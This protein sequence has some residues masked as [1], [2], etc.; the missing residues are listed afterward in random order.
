MALKNY[1]FTSESV[2]EGH[3]DKMCDQV[4]DAVL[5]AILAQDPMGR[6][7]CET[8]ITTGQVMI[9]GEVTTTA[10]IDIPSIVRDTIT[11]IG[12]TDSRF[13]FDAETCG[14]SVALDKQSPDIGQG[15]TTAYEKRAGG[16]EDPYDSQGAGD[17][18]L[19]FGFACDE[20]PTLM[21]L[22]IDLAHRLVEHHADLRKTG[23]LKW[24][25][26]DAKSQVT[27][28]YNADGTP[29]RVHTVVLSS[30][31]TQYLD[32][33]RYQ[34]QRLGPDGRLTGEVLRGPALQQALLEDRGLEVRA[35][36]LEGRDQEVRAGSRHPAEHDGR[37]AAHAHGV[38]VAGAAGLE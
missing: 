9:A 27:I 20:T 34:P 13:G 37:A 24:L 6:V 7:A 2:S 32:E 21:P 4:S 1:F 33:Q 12:Y 36:L 10:Q 38:V 3:P 30:L 28:E 29:H 18:G 11:H 25:R 26:P 5:D 16:E 19:M 15:V 31:L 23:K 35:G 14:V 17:Q 8:L 22:P